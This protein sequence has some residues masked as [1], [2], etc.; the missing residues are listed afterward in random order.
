MRA[1]KSS[2]INLW[3]NA[4]HTISL[5]P[6]NWCVSISL[7]DWSRSD[8][9]NAASPVTGQSSQRIVLTHT[10]PFREAVLS[11][12]LWTARTNVFN[13]VRLSRGEERKRTGKE[14]PREAFFFS[15][16]G[17]AQHRWTGRPGIRKERKGSSFNDFI[18]LWSGR[19]QRSH[20]TRPDQPEKEKEVVAFR[21]LAMARRRRK[22]LTH[23]GLPPQQMNA[24]H[25]FFV[26][27]PVLENE[28]NYFLRQRKAA[29]TQRINGPPFSQKIIRWALACRQKD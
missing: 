15:F 28:G 9:F 8:G 26:G 10:C 1:S 17:Q 19:S 4:K 21:L 16:P 23:Q 14:L 13:L 24:D 18:F 5:W 3:A 2:F 20:D 6:T 22:V 11:L 27:R 29:T 7:G 12:S 25:S